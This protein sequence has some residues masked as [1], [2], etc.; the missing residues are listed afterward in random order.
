VLVTD[1]TETEGVMTYVNDYNT[2]DE[3]LEDPASVASSSRTA[4]ATR[5]SPA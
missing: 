2:D 4:S 1:P 5:C 3:I